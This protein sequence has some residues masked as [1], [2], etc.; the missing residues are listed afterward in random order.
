MRLLPPFAPSCVVAVLVS[1]AAVGCATY[2]DDLARGQRAYTASEYERA[3]AIFRALEPDMSHLSTTERAQYAYLRGMTDYRM[4]YKASARHWLAIAAA[5]EKLAPGSLP[6][7]T[8]GPTVPKLMAT[9]KELNENVY[10]TQST[11]ALSDTPGA[12]STPA[13]SEPAAGDS[14]ESKASKP[15][16]APAKQP[17]E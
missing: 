17:D 3:L 16:D 12:A 9:L 1:L 5:M 6:P 11:I 7:D 4:G 15:A 10:Q 14:T 2:E 8:N 13:W